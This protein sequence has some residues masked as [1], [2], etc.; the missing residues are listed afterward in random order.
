MNKRK[1]A[2]VSVLAL[3]ASLIVGTLVMAMPVS[4]KSVLEGSVAKV[5]AVGENVKEGDALLYV[6]TIG[7]PMVAARASE[8]GKVVKVSVEKGATV[9]V[10]QDIAVIDNGK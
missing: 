2:I 7:G 1:F 4:Q 3:C 6:E 9:E 8:S 10:G 5:V